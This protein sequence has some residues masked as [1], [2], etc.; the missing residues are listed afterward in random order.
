MQ[1]TI[2][3]RILGVS[4]RDHILNEEIINRTR[5]QDIIARF[6][7]SKWSLGR[8]CC[9][10]WKDFGETYVQEW[11]T[12]SNEKLEDTFGQSKNDSNMNLSNIAVLYSFRGKTYCH[13]K[14]KADV[15][16][17]KLDIVR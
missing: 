8:T 2:E 4:I 15:K 10:T 14:I 3:R 16:L 13:D 5:V 17:I 1:R 11:M 6:A 12:N 7:E 9:K